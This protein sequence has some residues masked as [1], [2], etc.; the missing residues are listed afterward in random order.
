M[1]LVVLKQV[2]YKANKCV[3]IE[4]R[5]D[6]NINKYY[7]SQIEDFYNTIFIYYTIK[8]QEFNFIVP[9]QDFLNRTSTL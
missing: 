5:L 1:T 9:L 7:L 2:K 4:K 3:I 6:N 8:F